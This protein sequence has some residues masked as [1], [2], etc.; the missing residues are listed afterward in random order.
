M[1]SSR[2]ALVDCEPYHARLT[3]RSCADRHEKA[4]GALDAPARVGNEAVARKIRLRTLRLCIGC[5]TGARR[6]RNLAST[7]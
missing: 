3:A 6:R 4:N 2:F 7:D 5:Q 1:S